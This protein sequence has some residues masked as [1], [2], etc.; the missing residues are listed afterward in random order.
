MSTFQ[1][2]K[3]KRQPEIGYPHKKMIYIL[4]GVPGTGKTTLA[5]ILESSFKDNG[6]NVRKINRDEVREKLLKTTKFKEIFGKE[7]TYQESFSN[8]TANTIIRDEY[9]NKLRKLVN[10]IQYTSFKKSLLIIDS[11][12]TKIADLVG[13]L[14]LFE[15]FYPS[16]DLHVYIVTKKTIHGNV[17]EVPETVMK[18]FQKELKESDEWLKKKYPKKE[19]VTLL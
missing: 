6:W 14:S 1:P 3:R 10:R 7:L 12:H 2:E 11:T 16:G 8:V 18:N 17:H 9:Y 15:N 5:N 19:K 13:T 4:R